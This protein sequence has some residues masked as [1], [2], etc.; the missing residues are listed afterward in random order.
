MNQRP[1]ELDKEIE[2]DIIKTLKN[3]GFPANQ[4]EWRDSAAVID[5]SNRTL[6]IQGHPVMSG[7]EEPYMRK[8]AEIATAS[9]GNGRVLELGYGLGISAGFI[10]QNAPAEHV[11]IEMN[12]EIASHGRQFASRQKGKVTILEGFWQDIVPQLET[13]SFQGILFD[14]YPLSEEEVDVIFYPFLEHAFRLL[15]SGGTLT[16]Y[17]DEA[18]WFS[19]EHEQALRDLGFSHID[20]V[21]CEIVPPADCEYWRQTTILAPIVRK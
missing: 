8:L 11:I 19:A 20:G 21:L 2:S 18:T 16:Y 6:R 10:Q 7:W 1:S 5:E 4:N 3:I 14:T 17:S 12:Q 15:G 13:G 9:A